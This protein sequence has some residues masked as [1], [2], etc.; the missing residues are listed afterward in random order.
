MPNYRDQNM[1]VQKLQVGAIMAVAMTA[2]VVSVLASSLL[3][4]QQTIPNTG[5]VK[6]AGVCVY[7]NSNCT[8]NVTT[9]NWGSLEAGAVVNLPVYIK[10][11]GTVPV[12]L[13]MTTEN[14]S[15]TSALSSITLSWNRGNYIL[16]S[17]GIIQAIFTLTISPDISGITSFSFDII[18]TGT[19]QTA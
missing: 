6:A 11:E 17:G 2:I 8:S 4:A 12:V 19:E 5:N 15:P 10:N 7:W 9:I 3:M 14:W 13:N 16:S 18:I 1:A